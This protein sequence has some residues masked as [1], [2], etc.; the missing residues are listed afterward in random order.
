MYRYFPVR[1]SAFPP[2]GLIG[3]RISSMAYTQ[4]ARGW[5][6]PTSLTVELSLSGPRTPNTTPL[7]EDHSIP[8]ASSS[9][10]PDYQTRSARCHSIRWPR[11]ALV[12]FLPAPRSG[13]LAL[14]LRH[15]LV[16]AW[17]HPPALL[18]L[19]RPSSRGNSLGSRRSPSAHATSK[20]VPL[21]LLLLCARPGLPATPEKHTP[22]HCHAD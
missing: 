21:L 18:L 4:N 14:R 6:R 8:P 17:L 16:P 19:H 12:N 13:R 2:P 5:I 20:A 9:A 3:A 1:S 10:V 7:I 11:P 15:V 22:S